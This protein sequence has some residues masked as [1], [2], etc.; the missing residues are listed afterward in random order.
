MANFEARCWKFKSRVDLLRLGIKSLV[1]GPQNSVIAAPRE[2]AIPEREEAHVQ[3]ITEITPK[4]YYDISTEGFNG[5]G[6]VSS[7]LDDNSP[8]RAQIGSSAFTP[9][10]CYPEKTLDSLEVDFP[11]T[12]A[13]HARRHWYQR[14]SLAGHQTSIDC[15]TNIRTSLYLMLSRSHNHHQ[16]RTT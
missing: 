4:A 13:R 14:W 6:R 10:A 7:S 8:P 5:K 15:C 3:L 9:T 11:P 1:W 16:T 2:N 12:T